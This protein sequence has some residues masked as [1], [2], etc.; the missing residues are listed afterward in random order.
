MHKYGKGRP[1]GLPLPYR[2]R[3]NYAFAASRSLTS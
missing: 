1:S 2:D 3:E